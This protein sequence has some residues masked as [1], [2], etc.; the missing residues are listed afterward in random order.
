VEARVVGGRVALLLVALFACDHGLSRARAPGV[1]QPTDD[2]VAASAVTPN[3]NPPP[4]PPSP[5]PTPTQVEVEN[6]HESTRLVLVTIDGVR[7]EDVLGGPD[8]TSASSPS[9]E[10]EAMPTLKR[11]VRERGIALGGPGCAHDVRASGPNFVSLPG[12]LEMFTGK[13]SSCTHN[14]CPPVSTDTVIDEARAAAHREGDVAVFASWNK[15]GY[16][17]AHD[18]RAI[19]MSTGAS[20]ISL[21]AAKQDERLKFLLQVGQANA[22]F[23][24]HVDYRPDLYTGRIALRYLE[25]LTP[26]LLVV[27]LGDADEQAHRGDIPGYRRAIQRADDFIADLDRT[28]ARMGEDGKKTA[29]IVTTDHGRAHSLRAH[30]AS[31]PESQRVFVAAFG[32]GIAHRGVTCATEPLRLSHIAGVMRTLLALDDKRGP[33][34]TAIVDDESVPKTCGGS[35]PNTASLLP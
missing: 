34:A 21:R 12:Y 3:P 22:G 8:V 13:T 19:V 25:T 31:F 15:Y 29:V 33:L 10:P 23:P 27:G 20:A 35:I 1:D 11:L 6:A 16:A 14:Y 32:A 9:P 7:W 18:R 5:A 17:A 4:P 24:G 28:L 30:G 26:R 2:V